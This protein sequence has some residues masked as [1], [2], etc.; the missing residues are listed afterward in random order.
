MMHVG[1]KYADTA[2]GRRK[3]DAFEEMGEAKQEQK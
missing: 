2:Q 3:R 1:K